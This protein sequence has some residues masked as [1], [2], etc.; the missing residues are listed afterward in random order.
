VQKDLLFNNLTAVAVML[1]RSEAS[2][3]GVDFGFGAFLH[4]SHKHISIFLL[5]IHWYLNKPSFFQVVIG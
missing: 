4:Y 1:E 3:C 2:Q 5:L